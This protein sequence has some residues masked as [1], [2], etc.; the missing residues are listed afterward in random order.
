MPRLRAARYFQGHQRIG[1]FLPAIVQC[2]TA[3]T[4]QILEEMAFCQEQ[5]V[6]WQEQFTRRFVISMDGNG[7]TCS[8]VAIALRSNSVLIKYASAEMLYYFHG[9]QEWLHYI[10]V[11]HDRD[12][13]ALLDLGD[14]SPRSPE[15]IAYAGRS[16]AE[17]FLT[18]DSIIAYTVT[19]LSL[20]SKCFGTQAAEMSAVEPGSTTEIE[21]QA[22]P[23]T[24]V[25]VLAHVQNA[26]DRMSDPTG[27]SGHPWASHPIE[28]FQI[29][30]LDVAALAGIT[31]RVFLRMA[32]SR[33]LSKL[34]P[35]A[36]RAARALRCTGMS[37]RLPVIRRSPGQCCAK[38]ASRTQAMSARSG[39]ARC[40]IAFRRAA[41]GDA[42]LPRTV[43]RRS[44]PGEG[45]RGSPAGQ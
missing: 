32:A 7:A 5:R 19:L 26:G 31:C 6:S 28:G 18:R 21:A 27:W 14:W 4:R 16:F 30:R 20:Y 8:R 43:V 10:P 23:C 39:R 24:P 38:A 15:E 25:A 22:R 13:D 9:L 44:L 1:F 35:F 12:L 34:A 2:D 17:R 40:A 37:W 29:S 45:V 36:G 3:E 11:A 33:R 41:D 42:Y